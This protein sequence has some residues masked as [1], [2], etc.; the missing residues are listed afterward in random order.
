MTIRILEK[1]KEGQGANT[2][3]KGKRR[4][5]FKEESGGWLNSALQEHPSTLP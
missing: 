3:E 5:R 1:R 4:D 2:P